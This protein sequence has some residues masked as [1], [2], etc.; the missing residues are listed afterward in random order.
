MLQVD[1][2]SQE[3]VVYSTRAKSVV[4]KGVEGE[5]QIIPGHAQL[6]T[7]ILPG[8]VRIAKEE[9]GEELLYVSGG[10]VEVQPT[11]V[12]I[13]ADVVER[14]EALDEAAAQNAKAAAEKL[15]A[16]HENPLDAKAQQQLLLEARAK[17]KVL[18][19]LRQKNKRR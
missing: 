3:G 4:L 5:L 14:A 17:L 8:P 10:I 11:Q 1:I 2:V 19:L 15:L 12:S 9:Q 6:L 13:L 18:E 7:Q 16:G